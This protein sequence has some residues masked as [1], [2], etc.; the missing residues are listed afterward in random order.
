MRM[1]TDKA[2]CHA[3]VVAHVSKSETWGTRIS[4]R[5]RSGPPAQGDPS[6]TSDASYDAFFAGFGFGW[7]S[8]T[9]FG[10]NSP[11]TGFFVFPRILNLLVANIMTALLTLY[12]IPLPAGRMSLGPRHLRIGH[13]IDQSIA[14]DGSIG[15]WMT[16]GT[17]HA[18][19][20]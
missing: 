7:G 1:I 12:L 16:S 10:E 19:Y 15:P 9:T 11:V 4:S 14:I 5:F 3:T 17:L 6:T 18:D 20:P 2:F 8:F 13:P